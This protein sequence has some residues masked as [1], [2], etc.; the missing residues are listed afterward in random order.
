MNIPR[1]YKISGYLS[2]L[3]GIL[4]ALCVYRIQWMYYGMGMAM[5]GFIF[6]TVNIFLNTKYFN[7]NEKWPKGYFGIFLSSLPV[8]FLMFVINKY[9]K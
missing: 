1:L 3:F 5:M 7:D 8:L 6:G 4:A 9:K 2:L